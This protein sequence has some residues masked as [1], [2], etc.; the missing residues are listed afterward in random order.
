MTP[1][2]SSQSSNTHVLEYLDWYCDTEA[3]LGFAVLLRGHWGAGKTYLVE[4]Y[5]QNRQDK[6]LKHLYVSLYGLTSTKQI[7][8]A[9]FRQL[10]PVLASKG[11]KFATAVFKGF[12][13]T[14]VKVDLDGDSKEDLT[15]SSQ[16]PDVDL[17]SYFSS[18]QDR[19]LV[20]DDLERC[21]MKISDV[22]GY[23][24][25][26]VE[27]EDYKAI[28]VANED[29]ILSRKDE[30]YGTI[31]EKLIGQTLEV[32]PDYDQALKRFLGEIKDNH[33]RIFLTNN[34]QEIT[35][36]FGQSG[37]NNLR[38]LRQSLWDFERLATCFDVKHWHKPNAI[39]AVFRKYFPLALEVKA[40][41]LGVD[42]LSSVVG[43][44]FARYLR[45]KNK[46]APTR[47]DEVF[48]R[49]P[50]ADFGNTIL[51]E[52]VLRDALFK[53]VMRKDAVQASLNAHPFF[54][55]PASEAAWRAA[56]HGFERS[57]E[58]LERAAATVEEEF[59]ARSFVELGEMLHVFGLRLHLAKIGVISGDPKDIVDES[60]VYVD[61]LLKQGRLDA[62]FDRLDIS[63]LSTGWGGLGIMEV[64]TVEYREIATHLL[65]KRRA[66]FEA[67]YPQVAQE[68][69]ELMS[70][71]PLTFLRSICYNEYQASPYAGAPVLSGISA[72]KFVA[73]LL[74]L[75]PRSQ[76]TVFQALKLRYEAGRLTRELDAERTW[77]S[78]VVD[79]LTAALPD[80]R[81]N[82]RH[83]L[84][85]LIGRNLRPILDGLP[86]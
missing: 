54:V 71:D 65:E 34:K 78:Q 19:L 43:N 81:P 26:F 16:M 27:H 24:N 2:V 76:I 42:D 55:D 14:T 59:K 57:D 7:D 58:D 72:D 36:I 75:D 47:A 79:R 61:D 15:V 70:K 18:T 53:G 12:V 56:W 39:A 74:R 84:T 66:A 6:G 86:A 33:A 4:K 40:G 13:K 67:A 41:R 44:G 62:S 68:L 45:G 77:L 37:T 20:F 50:D 23:I 38:L 64:G 32:A 9:F 63:D 60:K 22:L 11:M 69:I 80:L 28:I 29:D 82:S 46:E 51:T 52:E 8:E 10:H 17:S 83:R 25:S 1:Q 31:K 48:E 85:S 73:E 30:L 3:V 35:G 49:Y 5:L 21:S